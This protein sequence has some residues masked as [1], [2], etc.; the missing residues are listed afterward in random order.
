MRRILPSLQEILT[1]AVTVNGKNYTMLHSS[2]IGPD[3]F[4]YSI[5][6]FF[7][8]EKQHFVNGS[9]KSVHVKNGIRS[10]WRQDLMNSKGYGN[11]TYPGERIPAQ[12][13]KQ[14]MV[15]PDISLT[16]FKDPVYDGTVKRLFPN[17]ISSE[18]DTIGRRATCNLKSNPEYNRDVDRVIK[19]IEEN[20]QR[21]RDEYDPWR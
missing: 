15:T 20:Y 1:R 16:Y 4:R 13:A 11:W 8:R 12:E 5:S 7:D 18:L 6:L 9:Y 10:T 3:N 14:H 17:E 2:G 19:Q 21:S